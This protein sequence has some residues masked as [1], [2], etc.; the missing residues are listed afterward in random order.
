MS[1]LKRQPHSGPGDLVGTAYWPGNA[2]SDP[3]FV[4]GCDGADRVTCDY[5]DRR[6]VACATAWCRTHEM[7]VDGKH[8]CR[9]HAR[10]VRAL[11]PEELRGEIAPPDVG[12]R[13]PALVAY[14]GEQLDSR[15]RGLLEEMRRP[16]RGETVSAEPLMLVTLP[17]AIR[18]WNLSWTLYDNTGM[19]LRVGIDV[20]EGQDTELA[21]RVNSRVIAR[22][23]PPWIL[24]R[25]AGLPLTGADDPA[26]REAF[27]DGLI[28]LYFRPAAEAEAR[29]MRRWE[30]S[31][32]A[33]H[34]THSF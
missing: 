14:V 23:V 32:N 12:N 34:A 8:L 9:R 15:I 25:K 26:D 33:P 17:P 29:W 19:T 13:S 3:C 22:C 16:E 21:L 11:R 7:V 20:E 4:S 27:Y 1:W 31:L 24:R 28:G 2:S 10:L 30:P 6:G 18:R 5:R